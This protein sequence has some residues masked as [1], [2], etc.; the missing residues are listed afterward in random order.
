MESYD[1]AII[2]GGVAGLTA[3]IMLANEGQRVILF[4]KSPEFGGRSQT[5][6]KNGVYMNLGAHAL[7]KGGEAMRIFN[8]LGITIKGAQPTTD[9]AQA[10]WKNHVYHVPMSFRTIFSKQFL[11][12]IEKIQLVQMMAQLSRMNVEAVEKESIQDWAERE[13]RNPMIRHFFYAFCRT[14]TQTHA[15]SLQLARPVLR[16]MQ[17]AF[18]EGVLYIDKGWA[19]IV[20]ELRSTAEKAGVELLN[21]M[22]VEKIEHEGQV[23]RVIGSNKVA[24]EVE[25]V[26]ITTPPN[27]ACRLVPHVENTS[28][29]QWRKEAIPATASCY[30]LGLRTLPDKNHQ[31]VIGLDIPIL[32][33][34]QSRTAKLSEDNTTVVSLVNYHDLTKD[35]KTCIQ[36]SKSLMEKSMDLIQPGWRGEVKEQQYLPDIAVTHNFP[37][38]NRSVVPGPDVSEIKGLYVAGD[39][40]GD[41]ELLVDASLASAKRAAS[42]I[43]KRNRVLI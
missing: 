38:I 37:H 14:A 34:N 31:F 16:Q 12:G 28:L 43:L 30:D 26:I 20:T 18:K 8:E 5:I 6:N 24:Y 7:Y 33:T 32:F 35:R 36:T 1:V 39:W 2:G 9:S 41:E 3:A 29:D 23:Q 15:P 22:K 40:V 10:I 13:I 21:A 4:E 25:N 42:H 17:R 27:E 11:N 19:T